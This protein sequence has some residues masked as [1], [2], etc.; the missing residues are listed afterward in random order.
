MMYRTL[1]IFFLFQFSCHAQVVM[2]LK[3]RFESLTNRAK[4]CLVTEEIER[5]NNAELELNMSEPINQ[6]DIKIE[7]Y[8][9]APPDNRIR[10]ENGKH[11]MIAFFYCN[12][13]NY[14]RCQKELKKINIAVEDASEIEKDKRMYARCY[15]LKK[16]PDPHK[17]LE[18]LKEIEVPSPETLFIMGTLAT[19]LGK[20]NK[21]ELKKYCNEG[22]K[23]YNKCLDSPI[24]KKVNDALI[25]QQIGNI[26]YILGRKEEAYQNWEKSRKTNSTQAGYLTYFMGVSSFEQKDYL[27]AKKFFEDVVRMNYE[28]WKLESQYYLGLIEFENDRI[29]EAREIFRKSISFNIK[30]NPVKIDI[31]RKMILC[32]LIL[33]EKAIQNNQE[34]TAK[35]I[36]DSGIKDVENSQLSLNDYK[37]I[38]AAIFYGVMRRLRSNLNN[39]NDIKTNELFANVIKHVNK[40]RHKIPILKE[41]AGIL[42]LANETIGASQIYEKIKDVDIISENNYYCVDKNYKMFTESAFNLNIH[43]NPKL[44]E[45]APYL[46]FNYSQFYY[47]SRN[48]MK[49]WQLSKKFVEYGE[50]HLH[51]KFIYE[52]LIQHYHTLIKCC[53]EDTSI[54]RQVALQCQRKYD[55]KISRL[56]D[57]RY[58]EEDLPE[59]VVVNNNNNSDLVILL[60][61]EYNKN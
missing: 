19:S 29:D 16:K 26:F 55:N 50:S 60:A 22:L 56:L 27:N 45:Y 57:E 49:V 33:A 34:E 31:L 35:S 3:E 15:L 25:Y 40:N 43:L 20:G 10:V 54:P 61:Y 7:K 4:S 39:V 8:K 32:N 37:N 11:R 14:L 5:R 30:P 6:L 2:N 38:D 23:H 36:L 12:N 13:G 41:I 59:Y 53:M 9:K 48:F 24:R 46:L 21:A 42:Y 52:L 44:H 18:T 17:A 47:E 51:E 1:A 58:E 28:D